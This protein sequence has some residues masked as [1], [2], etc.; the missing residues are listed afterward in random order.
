[1]SSFATA[2][3][4][5]CPS[6]SKSAYAN[7]SCKFLGTTWHRTCFACT[8]CAKGLG[9][10]VSSACDNGGRPYCK[11][12]YGKNFGPKGVGFGNTMAD[13]GISKKEE[14]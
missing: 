12:C 4:N 7:E 8:T 11:A 3:S 9:G 6:C 1:M 10:D 13:T 2:Q 14:N 5:K